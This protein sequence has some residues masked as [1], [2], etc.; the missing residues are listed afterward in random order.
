MELIQ[1]LLLK[2]IS[3][4]IG[5]ASITAFAISMLVIPMVIRIS[6]RMKLM[7]KPNERKEHKIPTPTM[8]GIGIFFG[9]FLAVTI[10]SD[11]IH[12]LE[13]LYILTCTS[14]LFVT[15]IVDDL[16]DL[17]SSKKFIVQFFVASL[18][19]YSGIRIM[20]LG[21]LLGIYQIPTAIQYALTII[22]IV[23][24]TN[25]FNLLDGIDGL[26]G[27]ISLTNTLLF[28]FLF[29]LKGDI[30]FAL[31]SFSLATAILGFLRFNFNPAKIFM[32][33]TGSLVIGFM[34]CV[35]GI[36]YMNQ[37]INDPH[38]NITLIYGIFILPVFDTLRVFTIRMLKGRSPFS[39]DRNHIHHLLGK[40]GLNHKKSAIIMYVANIILIG[41]ALLLNDDFP[42]FISLLVLSGSAIF[43]IE[44]L[45]IKRWLQNNIRIKSI[46][47]KQMKRQ[48]EN[49]LLVKL[50]N[51]K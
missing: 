30:T 14:L 26:V 10:W 49:Q 11:L 48:S 36:K 16:K 3:T 38:L 20:S 31:I 12:N 21:G 15:G 35:L 45:T 19:A 23:G 41:T 29:L 2:I 4:H 32:G 28:G 13:L 8:G 9:F 42:I 6:K 18:I 39:A 37:S 34:I 51:S 40:T 25:A 50:N 17:S 24:V 43:L 7:D 44:L 1:K 22:V 46:S 33:D 27:G 47:S 5:L